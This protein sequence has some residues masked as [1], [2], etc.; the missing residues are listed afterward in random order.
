[1]GIGDSKVS[2]PAGKKAKKKAS[3]RQIPLFF[4]SVVLPA[5]QRKGKGELW[6][7]SEQ[8]SRK[9]VVLFHLSFDTPVY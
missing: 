5:P 8:K 9:N 2:I 3:L 4:N 7:E 6:S 1:M